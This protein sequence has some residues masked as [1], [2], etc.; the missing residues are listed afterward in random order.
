M[1][2]KILHNINIAIVTSNDETFLLPTWTKTIN[3]LK[4][5]NI[6][7][8]GIFV[9]KK[10]MANLEPNKLYFWYLKT[11]GIKNFILLTMFT[12]LSKVIRTIKNYPSSFKDLSKKNNIPCVYLKNCEE[13]NFIKWIKKNK[14]D[15]LLI[16]TQDI[17]K[18]ELIVSVKKGIINKHASILPNSRG[19]LP[20]FWNVIN[21]NEQGVTYHAI[22]EKIDLGE[23]LLQ[24]EVKKR[25]I[26]MIGYY[27][28]IFNQYPHDIYQSLKIIYKINN[29]NCIKKKNISSY[30]SIP[31]KKDFI[32]FKKKGGKIILLRDFIKALYF[33]K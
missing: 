16:T 24:K 32:I 6:S 26:S 22:S 5:K 12:L 7:L 9:S 2:S 20:F 25:N 17:L 4:K 21:N 30:N 1:K 13:R 19:L 11:F 28:E 15:I 10:E 14:I 29:K 3:F 23:I 27:L 18:K 31:E 33:N 8:K